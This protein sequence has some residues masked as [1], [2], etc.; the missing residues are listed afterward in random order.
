[1]IFSGSVPWVELPERVRM[2]AGQ[3]GTLR[4]WADGREGLSFIEIIYSF[5]LA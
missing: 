2:D 4:C 3:R 5:L 1:M